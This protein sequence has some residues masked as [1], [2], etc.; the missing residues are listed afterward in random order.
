MKN[1]IFFDKS[2]IDWR[3]IGDAW[4]KGRRDLEVH[5]LRTCFDKVM[6]PLMNFLRDECSK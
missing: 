3:V 5:S 6:D 1:V 4:L 2:T